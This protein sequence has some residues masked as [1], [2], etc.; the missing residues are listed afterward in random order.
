MALSAKHNAMIV[1]LLVLNATLHAHARV[2]GV[3]SCLP[4]TY[5]VPDW[6]V[7]MG[8][9]GNMKSHLCYKTTLTVHLCC[10]RETRTNFIGCEPADTS[11]DVPACWGSKEVRACCTPGSM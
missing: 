7:S 9:I 11:R 1:L 2:L 8:T 10:E 3:Q 4:A 6:W 5:G